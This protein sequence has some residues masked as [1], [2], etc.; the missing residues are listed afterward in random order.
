MSLPATLYLDDG[1]GETR[2]L[3]V[4]ASGRP[5]RLD[6]DRWSER[7]ERARLDEFWWGRVC[8]K[9]PGRRAW[10]ID[11]GL[12]TDALVEPASHVRLTEGALHTFRVKSESWSGKST[13]LSLVDT[14]GDTPRADRPQRL[15]PALHDPFLAGVELIETIEEEP[16]RREVDSAIDAAMAFQINLRGGGNIAIEHTRAMTTIDVDAAERKSD[17]PGGAFA[18]ALNKCAAEE[19]AR[20][21]A[22]RAI[23]GLV[24]IDFARMNDRSASR[25]VVQTFS[26]LLERWLGRSSKVLEISSLGVCEASIAR[27]ARPVADCLA[28]PAPER[29]AIEALRRIESAGRTARGAQLRARLS[30][31]ALAWLDRDLIDWRSHLADRIGARWRLETDDRPPGRADVWNT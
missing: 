11:L 14:P 21:I 4:D 8:A 3:L 12:K 23:G 20:Q 16:A 27:R 30:R 28:A 15:G 2:R 17:Q 10:F 6:I 25:T 9:M 7:G 24:M 31:E 5:F 26:S 22:L 1:V 19:A 18:L 29:E 13:V